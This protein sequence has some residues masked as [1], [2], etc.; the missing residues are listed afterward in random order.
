MALI[1]CPECGKEISDK[2]DICVNCGFPIKEHLAMV[3]SET[4][5]EDSNVPDSDIG[6]SSEDAKAEIIKYLLVFLSD[7]EYWENSRNI[8]VFF[9]DL[10][11]C[12]YT[13]SAANYYY[14][15]PYFRYTL[16]L[17]AVWDICLCKK[18]GYDKYASKD[19]VKQNSEIIAEKH[20]H[21]SVTADNIIEQYSRYRYEIIKQHDYD[22]RTTYDSVEDK[23][24][25]VLTRLDRYAD[26][27]LD[28]FFRN[29]VYAAQSSTNEEMRVSA[30]IFIIDIR[31]YL[32]R[33]YDRF[34]ELALI[35][36]YERAEPPKLSDYDLP[37]DIEDQY[38]RVK[39][40]SDH[41]FFMKT[42]L[43]KTPPGLILVAIACIAVY[44]SDWVWLML[45]WF[46]AIWFWGAGQYSDYQ[47]WKY[48]DDKG[49]IYKEYHRYLGDCKSYEEWYS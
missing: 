19:W 37:E 45:A 28:E 34:S 16:Y 10:F 42:A 6:D 4:V 17:L 24:V 39:A 29:I 7:R 21:D 46:P 11:A 49:G 41:H 8:D 44:K 3:S 18:H 47:K 27:L 32:S 30:Q 26:D 48:I 14:E 2:A 5:S 22:E 43:A 12:A 20:S 31:A 40:E 9:E 15:T 35:D 23:G 33:V 38:K 25:T 36:D 13:M 1:T